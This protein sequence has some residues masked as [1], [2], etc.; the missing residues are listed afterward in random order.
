[1]ALKVS[2]KADERILVGG[3]A[4]KNISGRTAMLLIENEVPLLREK[5]IMTEKEAD[6]PCR[7]IYLLTQ[8]MY[9]DGSNLAKYHKLYWKLARE[10]I[11][12]APSTLGLFEIV[13]EH[14]YNAKYYHALKEI[15]KIIQYEQKATT[16]ALKPN[17]RI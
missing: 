17:K 5:E 9:V 1:M 11:Q 15:R 13:S 2:L 12:A 4:I 6:T 8:L 10:I 7:R 14:I 16:N 3:A